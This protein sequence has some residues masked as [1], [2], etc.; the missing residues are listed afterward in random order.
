MNR[1][2]QINFW[3]IFFVLSSLN[4]ISNTAQANDWKFVL[5]PYAQ[6][7]VISGDASLGRVEGADV[8]VS[9]SDIL[10]Q[11]ELG[12]ML[13]MEAHHKSGFG[14]SLNYSFMKL[15]DSFKGPAGYTK[16]ESELFQ[17][18]LEAYLSYRLNNESS[19]IDFYTGARWWDMDINLEA[20]T[21]ISEA[22]LDRDFSW[23]DPVV[24]VRYIPELSDNWRLL[25]QG[26][27]GGFEVQS[28]SSYNI[29][30]GL[31]WDFDESHS[32]AILYRALWVD[33][34]EGDIGERD[35]FKY[36]TVTHGPSIGVVFR[37]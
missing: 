1:L 8:D 35:R 11:L 27:L 3:I 6:L 18:V 16:F 25:L 37:F 29:M 34:S 33:Y 15:E 32:L 4:C 31:L 36:D 13:Q 7:P 5:V 24:G 30:A 10:D 28:E 23:V 14:T 17:A 26:D 19:T 12:G 21:A 22:N 9:M 20:E 2:L